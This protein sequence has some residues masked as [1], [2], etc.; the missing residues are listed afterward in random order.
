[1]G[2][3]TQTM[4]FKG[5][6]QYITPHRKV[7]LT[8]LA[9]LI[10]GSLVSLANPWMAGMLTASVLG[11]G[12]AAMSPRTLIGLW[13]ALMVVRSVLSFVTDY[14]IAERI[15]AQMRTRLYQHL[16]ALPIGYY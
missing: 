9:L 4:G 1:M 6:L 5:L 10:V 13:F 2:N 8:I 11:N 3:Q 12:E 14:F 16:Q 15:T 7:L